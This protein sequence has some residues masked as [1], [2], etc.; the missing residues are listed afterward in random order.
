MFSLGLVRI[1]YCFLALAGPTFFS[2]CATHCSG[3]VVGRDGAPVRQALVRA[4]WGRD[5]P[6]DRNGERTQIEQ[7]T[8]D[9][10]GYFVFNAAG[11]PL[12]IAADSPDLKRSGR[13]APHSMTNNIVVVD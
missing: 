7:T 13:L 5:A 2:G 3:R 9:S 10:K 1:I 6:L 12:W 8:T 4:G 11:K